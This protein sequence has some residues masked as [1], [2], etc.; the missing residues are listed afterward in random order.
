VKL[1]KAAHAAIKA[2]DPGAKVV[3]AALA[4]YA[5]RYLDKIYD[6][7]GR[8]SFDIAAINFFSSKP[9]NELRALR[10]VRKVMRAH[11]D[12]RKQVWLTEVTWP[13]AKGRDKPGVPWQ[14]A[15]IQ[16]DR[17][18]AKRLTEVYK[19]LVRERR[20][21]RLGRVFWYTWS[22][23]YAAGDL[24]D[25]GGLTRYR[26]GSFEARPALSAYRKSAR[27]YQGCAKTDTGACQ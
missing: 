13:A 18:M 9:R 17:G 15:W 27:R 14:K 2:A 16:T 20:K 1:L 6:Q 22:S 5:W 21:V 4:D 3:A 8:G 19:L 12:G 25:F 11:H 26:D 10:H 23:G 24:F 7:R